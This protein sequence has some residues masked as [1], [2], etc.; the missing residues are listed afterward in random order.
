MIHCGQAKAASGDQGFS[1]FQ[2][3][4]KSRAKTDGSSGVWQSRTWTSSPARMSAPNVTQSETFTT[5]NADNPLEVFMA[6]NDSR[7]RNFGS[8]NISGGSFSSDGG[9]TFTRLTRGER[10]ESLITPG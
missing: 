4:L 9:N 8:I 3:F 6:T 1:G 5:A 10:P 2:W 7:G